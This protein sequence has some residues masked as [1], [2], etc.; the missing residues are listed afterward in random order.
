[1][2]LKLSRLW[3]SL[4]KPPYTVIFV[5]YRAFGE[6]DSVA[7]FMRFVNSRHRRLLDICM[8]EKMRSHLYEALK[9]SGVAPPAR[10]VLFAHPA[11]GLNGFYVNPNSEEATGDVLLLRWWEVEGRPPYEVLIAHV[12]RG[13]HVLRRSPWTRVFPKWISYEGDIRTF[14]ATELGTRRWEKVFASILREAPKSSEIASIQN[15]L[16]AVYLNA[17]ADLQDTYNERGGDALNLIYF[18]ECLQ[19]LAI[20][21]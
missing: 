21:E 3:R 9:E 20:S 15:R 12:C 7:A 18:Q 14:L 4:R 10:L 5:P 13:A 11:R 16:K 2:A 17:M 6:G 19:S 8:V 1:M